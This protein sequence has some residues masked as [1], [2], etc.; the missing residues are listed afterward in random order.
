MQHPHHRGKYL[1]LRL[2]PTNPTQPFQRHPNQ[3]TSLPLN[4]SSL[5]HPSFCDAGTLAN[6]ATLIGQRC[7]M[8]CAKDWL[9][10]SMFSSLYPS[11][12]PTRLAA[13]ALTET[14]PEAAY[15]AEAETVVSAVVFDRGF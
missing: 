6:A 9:R 7:S 10:A 12:L 13:S 3:Q 2:A 11:G 14:N 5:A 4:H 15:N 8:S 1:G